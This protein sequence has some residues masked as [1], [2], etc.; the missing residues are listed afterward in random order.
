MSKS[1][2]LGSEKK[3]PVEIWD[4]K[5]VKEYPNN[6]KFH[7][8]EKLKRLADSIQRSGLSYPPQVDKDGVLIT[9]HARKRAFE[10]LGRTK[11]PVIVR[12]D[13]TKIQIKRLRIDD[14]EVQ[15]GQDIAENLAMELFELNELGEDLSTTFSEKDLS[16]A[17]QD[18]GE[19][20]LDAL[21]DD[22]SQEVASF[23]NETQE[24]IDTEDE[25]PTVQ[26]AKALG[27][28]KIT[29]S[30]ERI[31]KAFLAHAE[32]QTGLKDGAALA[33]YCKDYIGI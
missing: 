8:D 25:K 14:N 7:S 23:S 30:Q 12:T 33:A 2:E 20:N 15:K 27:F 13:L 4:I 18:L 26:I 19:I 16:M 9:G 24:K 10:L 11:I 6:T 28:A 21:T 29:K 1:S 22:I 31:I 5:D 17:L 3:F 32:E